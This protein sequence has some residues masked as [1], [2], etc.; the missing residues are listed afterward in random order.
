M[1]CDIEVG[2]EWIERID[3]GNAGIIAFACQEKSY[4]FAFFLFFFLFFL[5]VA[6]FWTDQEKF[7]CVYFIICYAGRCEQDMTTLHGTHW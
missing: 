5:S 2:L 4:A 7:F 1:A 3:L 6:V